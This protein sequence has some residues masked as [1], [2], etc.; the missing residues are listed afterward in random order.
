MRVIVDD[1][2]VIQNKTVSGF[3]EDFKYNMSVSS[4]L[5]GRVEVRVT[6]TSD[7]SVSIGFGT[8]LLPPPFM[9]RPGGL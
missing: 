4:K 5:F 1:F 3:V 7:E 9:T 2:L 6:R 8:L